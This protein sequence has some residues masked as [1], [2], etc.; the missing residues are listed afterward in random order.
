MN[1]S[2]EKQLKETQAKIPK[3]QQD[4]IKQQAEQAAKEKADKNAR[5]IL[6][7]DEKSDLGLMFLSAMVYDMKVAYQKTIDQRLGASAEAIIFFFL[8]KEKFNAMN[9]NCLRIVL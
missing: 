2:I 8:P 9:V 1:D 6:Q 5:G 3:L 7:D 4:A